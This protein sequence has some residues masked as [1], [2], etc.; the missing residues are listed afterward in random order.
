MIP[1][2]SNE[3][4]Y[5]AIICYPRLMGSFRIDDNTQVFGDDASR[6]R[7]DDNQPPLKTSCVLIFDSV[8]GSSAR[9]ATTMRHIKDFLHSEWDA[10]YKDQMQFIKSS[11]ITNSVKCP[12]QSNAT[13]CGLFLLEFME[14]FFVGADP[15]VDFRLPLDKSDWFDPKIVKHKRKLIAMD[16][17]NL[18]HESGNGELIKSLP[19]L[20]FWKD[21]LSEGLPKEVDNNNELEFNN[22]NDNYVMD[23]NNGNVGNSADSQNEAAIVDNENISTSDVLITPSEFSIMTQP[24]LV[25]SP[26]SLDLLDFDHDSCEQI[27]DDSET[28]NQEPCYG[29]MEVE[30][31]YISS[32]K[33]LEQEMCKGSESSP[34]EPPEIFYAMETLAD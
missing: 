4:W 15:I 33:E 2:N 9:R 24:A 32:S 1:V 27:D 5:L 10:K 30:Q 29:Q 22:N 19:P 3:H 28:E 18:M 26:K 25:L 11:I 34:V 6:A 12:Q 14:R 20:S 17:Q 23:N 21:S 16:I 7:R 31:K 8:K 13:D